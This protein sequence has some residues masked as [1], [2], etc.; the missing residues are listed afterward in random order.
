MERRTITEEVIN[1]IVATGKWGDLYVYGIT[2]IADRGHLAFDISTYDPRTGQESHDLYY[3]T[4]S[5]ADT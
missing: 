4:T 3:L 5:P 1:E 2:D